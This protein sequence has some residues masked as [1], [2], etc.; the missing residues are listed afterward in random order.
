MEY[1]EGTTLRSLLE[2][3]GRISADATLAIARQLT[4]ALVCAHGEGIVHRDIKPENLLID[5]AGT[6]KLMD[7]GIAHLADRTCRLT[8]EGMI[9]GTPEYMS[10]EQLLAERVDAK[11]DLYSVGV[12]LYE[13]ITGRPPFEAA[14]TAALIAKVLTAGA[15]PPKMLTLEVPHALSATVMQLLAKDPAQRPQ[16][17]SDLREMLAAIA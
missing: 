13:C 2:A 4:E 5:A 12:V 7:F 8:E 15:L 9:V 17:A 16:R 11:S 6:V 14:S 10:P 3:R 1:V